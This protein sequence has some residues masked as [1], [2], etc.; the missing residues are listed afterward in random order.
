MKKSL[1]WR[2]LWTPISCSCC[3][4]LPTSQRAAYA[5]TLIFIAAYCSSPTTIARFL[6]LAHHKHFRP[7][8]HVAYEFVSV[9]FDEVLFQWIMT[10]FFW[11]PPESQTMFISRR[12]NIN[13]QLHKSKFAFSPTLQIGVWSISSV[14]YLV[15][16]LRHIL[17]WHSLVMQKIAFFLRLND[18]QSAL[19]MYQVNS[20]HMFLIVASHWKIPIG[21]L[22]KLVV[23]LQL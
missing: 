1:K 23:F 12:K 13:H 5:K 11:V 20:M 6:F 18:S 16:K 14:A 8:W 3:R 21:L 4:L 17:V 7:L 2:H 10:K 19:C 22:A 15:S 9:F